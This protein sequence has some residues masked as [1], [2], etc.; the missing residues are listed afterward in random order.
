MRQARTFIFSS[1][2]I[3]ILLILL[4]PLCV[5]SQ[6]AKFIRYSTQMGLSSNFQRCVIQDNEG[7][8]WIATG[9]GLNR[10]DGR[11]F[12]VYRKIPNDSTTLRSNNVLCMYVDSKGVLWIGTFQGGLSRYNKEKDNFST[13]TEMNDINS[14]TEDKFKR[15]WVGSNAQ[16]LYLL[17]SENNGFTRFYTQ[18]PN[19]IDSTTIVNNYI[20]RIVA[21]GDILWI[22]SNTGILTA[23]NTTTMLFKHYTI[24]HVS[25]YQTATFSV[26]SLVVDSNRIWIS[27]WSKGIWIFDKTTGRCIPDRNEK[28]KYINC[29][30]KDNNNR[31]WYSP[32]SKGLIMIDGKKEMHYQFNDFDRYSLS[33]NS[34]ADIFQDRQGNLWLASKQGDLNYF[35]LDNPFFTWYKNPNSIEGLTSNFIN[36]V[37]EDSKGRIW[38]GFENGG[39]DILDARNIK[40]KIHLKGDALTGLDP[41]PVMYIYESRNGTIWIGKYLDGLKKYNE[42]T[43][44]FSSYRHRENDDASLAANDV[45]SI[46]EDS[47]GN[48]WI[49]IHGGGVDK[50]IPAEGKFIHHKSDPSHP[51]NAIA[52]DWTFSAVCDKDENIWVGSINGVSV[53]SEQG[54]LVRHFKT[55]FA[56][57]YNLSNDLV[58]KILIDSKGFVWFGTADGLDRLDPRDNTIKAYFTKDGLPNNVIADIREDSHYNLW[59]STTK[60]LSKFSPENEVFQNYS[61]SDGLVTEN[62]NTFASFKNRRGEMYFGGRDGLIRFHPDSIKVNKLRPPVFLTDFK[63]FNRSVPVKNGHTQAE[64]CIPQQISFCKEVTLNYDQNVIT[65]EYIAL[66]YLNL[67]KNQYKYKL[68]GFEKDWTFAGNKRDVTYTNLHPGEYVFRVIASNNDGIWNTEGASLTII[69]NPPF[70]RTKWAYMAYTLLVI[71]LLYFF[72]KWILH[73]AGIKRMIELEELEIQKLHDMDNLK[74]QFFSN[75]SHEFRTP[76]TLITGPLEHLLRESKNEIQKIQIKL[77]QRNTN[78]LM[79]LINQLMD[80]RKIEEASLELNLT[81]SN[82]VGFMKE[83]VS[84]FNQEAK[85]R[86]I[87]YSFTSS[88][89]SFELWF[90]TDKLDKIIFNLLS[91]AFKYTPDDGA[92]TISLMM[93]SDTGD[94]TRRDPEKPPDEK[95]QYRITVKDSGIGIPQE[96]Q[97]NIFDRFYQVKNTL[98]TR[99]TGIGLSLTRELVKLHQGTI[100]VQSEPGKGSE[101]S[102]ILPL[103]IEEQGLPYLSTIHKIVETGVK[104]HKEKELIDEGDALSDSLMNRQD[105]SSTL[106]HVL[107]IEDN[108]D[109]RLFIINELLVHYRFSEAH[110]GTIGVEKAINEIPDLIICDIMMP[111]MD[112]YEVCRRL[113][114]D[115]RTS[116]IPV[117]MLT[118]RSSE[119]HTI[120]GLESGADDYIAKPFSSA[121]LRVRIKNL[122]NSR[123]LLRKKFIKEPFASLKD[124][125]PS[126]IDERLFKKAYELVEKNLDNPDFGILEFSHGLGMSRAQ[127][128]RKILAISGQSVKEFIRIIRLK[129]AAELL[130]LRDKNISEIAFTVGFNSLSYFTKSFTEYFGMN[131]TKYIEK[132]TK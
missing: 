47:K 50:F 10:F 57:R 40:P 89:P 48:L 79:R 42:A 78:R 125:S 73:E 7:F 122:I 22:S 80:F 85:E 127:L 4:T 16:G 71:A 9:D 59:I 56:E 82:I 91:N 117:I 64:F 131:P 18:K 6:P 75:V 99:G 121:I 11:T 61:I 52:T 8:I 65:L 103:W 87:H 100:D 108:A 93:E 68:E 101:F 66:N 74:T 120:E 128:Y 83:L 49:A 23:L 31:I 32:E 70:W 19:T 29:I 1:L 76:L 95:G 132:Y 94:R 28:S 113:K 106:P 45:R 55:N 41:G 54:P 102:V 43:R 46:S 97:S 27:T 77:I 115:E 123:K 36:A 17:N 107:I 104:Q 53:L 26:N 35:I 105:A 5:F 13:Y 60:G 72:R 25:S 118:A 110:N 44:S 81:K 62:F 69:V 112:G 67:E 20:N 2:L 96:S 84:A 114:Q 58:R 129:K 92:I 38:V 119:Q 126:K 116:H 88:H 34:L 15:L 3:W 24:F 37:I 14:I 109:M 33:S 90:D 111:G 86:N 12:K 98:T 30:V 51:S 63:L 124:I 39:I 21:D 130:L